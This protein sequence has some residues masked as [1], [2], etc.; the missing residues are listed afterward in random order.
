MKIYIFRSR[1]VADLYGATQDKTGANL[2]EQY[3][4][5]EFHSGPHE[6]KIGGGPLI[7]VNVDEAVAAIEKAGYFLWKATVTSRIVPMS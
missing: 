1:S 5:W 2:P 3:G 6:W 4:P 7:G